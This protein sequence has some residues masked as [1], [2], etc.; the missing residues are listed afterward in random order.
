MP[1]PYSAALSKYARLVMSVPG[2]TTLDRAMAPTSFAPGCMIEQLDSTADKMIGTRT[3]SLTGT[4]DNLKRVTPSMSFKPSVAEWGD[5]LQWIMTGTPTGTTTKTFPLGN[6]EIERRIGF[7]D[8]MRYWVMSEVCCNRATI[9]ASA[10]GPLTVDIDAIGTDYTVGSGT[11]PTGLTFPVGPPFMMT[12]LAIVMGAVSNVSCR[13]F[14]LS[15]DNV[16]DSNRYFF[17][18][19]ISGAVATDRMIGCDL[20]IPYG[21]HSTLWDAG[22]GTAGVAIA[23]T[24]T[25]GT[26]SL[27]FTMPAVKAVA[28]PPQVR[29]PA[30]T[31]YNWV[32]NAVSDTAN[33]EL[34]VTYTP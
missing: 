14:K 21:L 26:S 32:G 23:A 18:S 13:S 7:D 11:F 16:L 28:P 10:G 17:G 27:V 4:V 3:H 6:R 15:I 25:R 5:L 2:T 24:F 22:A 9:A 19:T 12:N 29:V 20:E 8:T 1:A 31:M 34:V 33:A 30:E